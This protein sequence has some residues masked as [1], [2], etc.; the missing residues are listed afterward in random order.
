MCE[1]RSSVTISAQIDVVLTLIARVGAPFVKNWIFANLAKAFFFFKCGQKPPG[2]P[3]YSNTTLAFALS[4]PHRETRRICISSSLSPDVLELQA[5]DVLT[6]HDQRSSETVSVAVAG[7]VTK[8]R[9]TDATLLSV[10]MFSKAAQ[11]EE[12]VGKSELA[13]DQRSSETVSV[14]VCCLRDD[15]TH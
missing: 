3:L 15:T 14:A 4:Q 5:V 13:H 1:S 6:R 8:V 7:C 9:Y 12:T 2:N 10:L 11:Y